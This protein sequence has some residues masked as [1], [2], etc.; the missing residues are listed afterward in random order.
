MEGLLLKWTNYLSGWQPRYFV[1]D[2]GI[3][4]YYDSPENV[5]RGSKGSIKM[6]V[7]EIQVNS[8]D[9]NR[10]D[11]I[12]PNEQCFYLRAQSATERQRW[13]VAL[14]SAKACLGE[15]ATQRTEE[16][17][18]DRETL[19]IKLSELQIFCNLL[20]QQMAE[21][22]LAVDPDGPCDSPDME[23]KQSDRNSATLSS[24]SVPES[25]RQAGGVTVLRKLEE[26]AMRSRVRVQQPSVSLNNI[27]TSNARLC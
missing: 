6:A 8:S 22:Q 3:L 13:L 24:H 23:V 12:I 5:G 19:A 17:P 11:L 18:S 14:G 26:M 10:M 4:S 15:S 1:L 27:T 7:C 20:M 2:S 16:V 9:D 25:S 21:V